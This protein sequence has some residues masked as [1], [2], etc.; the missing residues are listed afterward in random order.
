MIFYEYAMDVA[1]ACHARGVKTV[2]VTAGYMCPSRAP[3]SFAA[4]D[5]ANVDLKA[6]TEDFYHRLTAAHLAPVLDTLTYLKRET[7]VWLEITTLLIPGE[8]D[9]DRRNRRADALDRERAGA[10]RAAAFLRVPPGL[11]HD[12]TIRRRRRRRWIARARRRS[13][14]ASTTSTSAMSAI[15]PRQTTFC[16]LCGAPLI[17]RDDYELTSLR[18]RRLRRLPRVR[19]AAR[20][21]LRGR[22]GPL[23]RSASRS[24]SRLS[25]ESGATKSRSGL[26]ASNEHRASPCVAPAASYLGGRLFDHVAKDM[27]IYKEES[28]GPVLSVVRA[29]S[30]NEALGLCNDHDFANGVAIFTRD[31]DAARDFASK[32][33]VGMVGLNVPIPAPVAY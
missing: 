30:Y 28:F 3:N 13:P 24:T 15:P 26:K 12:R 22:A 7:D 6:F 17:G 8:N 31:G 9:F 19:R 20:R 25:L 16:D 18:A 14:T 27:R 23:G 33:E 32:V 10:G 21:P 11:P 5:A 29:A 1:A 4:I 2:A